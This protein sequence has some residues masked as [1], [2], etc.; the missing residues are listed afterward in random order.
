MLGII[1]RATERLKLKAEA[2]RERARVQAAL[3]SD[4]LAFD[5]SPEG[6]RV[7][8]YEQSSGRGLAAR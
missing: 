7:R 1:E 6:E 3:A 2:H 8:R 5:D 4:I